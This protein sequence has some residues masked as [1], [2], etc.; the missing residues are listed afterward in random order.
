MFERRT[1]RNVVFGVCCVSRTALRLLG[2]PFVPPSPVAKEQT[3]VRSQDVG[4]KAFGYRMISV[5]NCPTLDARRG[6]SLCCNTKGQHQ[7]QV[8]FEISGVAKKFSWTYSERK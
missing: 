5:L 3:T 8:V 1:P 2:T 4:C 7:E 6:Y